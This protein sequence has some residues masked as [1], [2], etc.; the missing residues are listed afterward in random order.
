MYK[1][2]ELPYFVSKHI[3]KILKCIILLWLRKKILLKVK[4]NKE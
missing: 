2:L 1:K 4:C 3:N